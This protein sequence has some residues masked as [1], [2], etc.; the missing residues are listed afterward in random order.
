M[1]AADPEEDGRAWAEMMVELADVQLHPAA[2]SQESGIDNAAT[3]HPIEN[4]AKSEASHTPIRGNADDECRICRCGWE[5]GPLL[6]PCKCS[7]SIRFVHAD[8]QIQWLERTQASACELCGHQFHFSPLYARHAPG[9]LSSLEF[10]FGLATLGTKKLVLLLRVMLV[11]VL[12][13]VCL[14]IGT[15]WMFR[16]FFF[17]A[18]HDILKL[19]LRLSLSMLLAD[20]MAG[21]LLSLMVVVAFL[22]ISA[23]REHMIGQEREALRIAAAARQQQRGPAVPPPVQRHVRFADVEQRAALR[24][25]RDDAM[26]QR[27]PAAPP[28][29]AEN[30]IDVQPTELAGEALRGQEVTSPGSAGAI[31]DDTLPPARGSAAG[32]DASLSASAQENRQTDVELVP[33]AGAAEDLGP[34][35]D[36][37]AG[38]PGIIVRDLQHEDGVLPQLLEQERQERELQEREREEEV[39]LEEFIGLRGPLRVIVENALT[40]LLSNSLCIALVT[41]IPFTLGRTVL[42]FKHRWRG[43]FIWASAFLSQRDIADQREMQDVGMLE[44]RY[45]DGVTL[46][47]GYA[48]IAFFILNLVTFS[49]LFGDRLISL[50]PHS[51]LMKPLISLLKYTLILI[52]V[53]SLLAIELVAFPIGCGWW[54]DLCTLCLVGSSLSQRLEVLYASPATSQFLHWLAGVSLMLHVSLL[55]AVLREVVR[56]EVLWFLR[57]PAEVDE[58]PLRDLVDEP[59]A[60]HARRIVL[61][62]LLYLPLTVVLVYCPVLIFRV[63][64]PSMLPLGVT[65]HDPLAVLPGP[66]LLLHV[67]LPCLMECVRPRECLKRLLFAFFYVTGGMLGIRDKVLADTVALD[68]NQIDEAAAIA[69][70]RNVA[71]VAR[72]RREGD[73]FQAAGPA[74][75]QIPVQRPGELLERLERDSP[76]QE[77]ESSLQNGKSV[78]ARGLSL[79]MI[80]C[81]V[82]GAASASC[83]M[84]SIALGRALLGAFGADVREDLYTFAA[85]FYLLSTLAELAMRVQR[86]IASHGWRAVAR[87]V[88]ATVV[89]AGKVA[90][91]GTLLLVPVP[92]MVGF[93]A[94]A[95]YLPLV[96]VDARQTAYRDRLGHWLMGLLLLKLSHHMICRGGREGTV[97]PELREKVLALQSQGWRRLQ[98]RSFVY[99]IALPLIACLTLAITIPY[100]VAFL[101]LPA[102]GA[103]TGTSLAAWRWCYPVT[104][105]AALLVFLV[106]GAVSPQSLRFPLMRQPAT[107][108]QRKRV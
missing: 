21:V 91:A 78:L 105:F 99:D 84:G 45:G 43:L 56:P 6:H 103:S 17:R 57:N 107:V 62:L 74:N 69:A 26:L 63:V 80:G 11:L 12:W 41:L 10:L 67:S 18:A 3:N 37:D 87:W 92:M 48:F 98:L 46:L 25:A 40:A 60:K 4:D 64:W 102:M 28:V 22:A 82:A 75:Q 54:V 33:N 61:S 15:A 101:V 52:K 19:R 7:G 83:L 49:I 8:C 16:I 104:L 71:A 95:A 72:I 79:L 94:D 2:L 85:G 13:L 55:V 81:I 20:W 100:L 5:I 31:E 97:F 66:V 24:V 30:E 53:V 23:L 59:L 32:G 90:V 47:T 51:P 86:R 65:L 68:P 34:I 39:P 76:A 96:R 89:R 1:A 108:A 73:E 58:H 36:Q 14:P 38:A 70:H 44:M 29:A 9:R 106:K 27:A 77:I 35:D 42:W 88:F 93:L 50:S